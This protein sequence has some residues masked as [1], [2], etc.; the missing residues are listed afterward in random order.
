ML[1]LDVVPLSL[2]IETEG[3]VMS[4]VVPR[5]TAI[6]CLKTSQFTTT[7]NSQ[8]SVEFP[9][10]EGERLLTKDNNLLGQFELNGKTLHVCPAP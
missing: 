8:T 5:N 1:L 6:P 4:V 3:G 2:G 7:E 9:V 10:Y